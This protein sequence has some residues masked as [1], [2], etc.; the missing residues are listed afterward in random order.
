M[1]HLTLTDNKRV[2]IVKQLS[3]NW[4]RVS[5]GKDTK[6]NDVLGLVHR[7]IVLLFD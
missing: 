6:G 7:T 5:Y 2:S 1:T 3:K 4:F